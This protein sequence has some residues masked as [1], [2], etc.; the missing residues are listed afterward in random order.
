MMQAHEI[1]LYELEKRLNLQVTTAA[2]FFTEWLE[3]ITLTEEEKTKCDRIRSQ[4]MRQVLYRRKTIEVLVKMLVLSPLLDIA[5]FY[6]DP[7]DISAED[8]IIIDEE[9]NNDPVRGRLDVLV[10]NSELW[11]AEIE[12]KGLKFSTYA[13][14]PQTLAYMYASPNSHDHPIFGMITNGNNFLFLKM[15]K[16]RQPEYAWSAKFSLL[17]PRKN[18]LY[19]V[20][21]ILKRLSTKIL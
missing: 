11:I 10:F 15:E 13:A 2:N 14:I 12:A 8:P 9:D 1:T 5:G 7:F 4:F 17:D 20:L 6:Q 21:G 3:P 18:S 16:T 19:E